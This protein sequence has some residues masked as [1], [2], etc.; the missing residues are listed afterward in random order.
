MLETL[1]SEPPQET[2]STSSADITTT[3]G[4]D[5]AEP[6]LTSVT[7]NHPDVSGPTDNDY[8]FGSGSSEYAYKSSTLSSSNVGDFN[9]ERDYSSRLTSASSGFTSNVRENILTHPVVLK[10]R[11]EPG[12]VS[13]VSSESRQVMRKGFDL[14]IGSPALRM[15][16]DTRIKELE[17]ELEMERLSK[18]KVEKQRIDL[19]REVSVL[20]EKVDE[21]TEATHTQTELVRRREADF[22]KLQKDL[23]D[24][25][26]QNESTLTAFR[27]KHQES[28]NQ[29]A[30]QI[31]QMQRVKQR[32]EKEKSLLKVEADELHSQ[33][34]QLT[35]SKASS[36]KLNKQLESQLNEFSNKLNEMQRELLDS[37][38]LRGRV[39]TD[40]TEL[41]RKLEES[42]SQLS[43]ANRARL[44]ASKQLEEAKLSLEDETIVRNK[45]LSDNR[46][47]QGQLEQVRSTLEEEQERVAELQRQVS[48]VTG[49]AS[50]WKQKFESG[51]GSIK[52]EEVEELKKKFVARLQ[53][54]ETQLEA[55]VSKAMGLEKAK[56]R[57]Q[58]EIE[59]LLGELEKSQSV[60]AQNE[61]RQ[62]Q[63][64]KLVE[65]WKRKVADLQVEL[66]SAQKES[67]SH[68][69]EVYKIKS[70][71]DESRETIETLRRDNKNL[72]QEIHD[73][74]DALGQSN[75][76]LQEVEKVSRRHEI[77][78]DE[79]Q[80]T[81]EEAEQ[82]LEQ[83]EAKM[84]RALM[85]VQAIKQDMERRL[86]EKEEEFENTRK[87]HQRAIESLQ[88]SL[89]AEARG[90]MDALRMKK[91]MEQDI[92]ELEM[93]LD[94]QNKS[95]GEVEKTFKKYQLQIRELQQL[96]DD[97]QRTKR[98]SKEEITAAE[99][100]AALLAGELEEMKSQIE[101]LE[102]SKKTVEGDLYE[103]A[104]RV[105]ELTAAN[106]S[107]SAA[108]KKLEADL[109]AAHGEF[110]DHINELKTMDDQAKKAMT[111][112]ARLAEEL[113]QEQDHASQIDKVRRGLE[114]QIKE[115]QMRL[116]ESE[117]SALHGGRKTIQTLEQ[118]VREVQGELEAEQHRHTETQKVT[119]KHE[120]RAQELTLQVEEDRKAQDRMHDMIDKMQSKM[121]S[122]KKQV[123]EAEEI[124]AINLT[125]YRKIQHDLE[126][127]ESRADMAENLVG[128]MRAKSR[129]SQSVCENY[130]QPASGITIKTITTRSNLS[131]DRKLSSD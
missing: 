92:N 114:A 35:K 127:S 82:A 58:L 115:L 122:Y 36:E 64:D 131:C 69:T 109:Q 124:A 40:N 57:A 42:E 105:T 5:V 38:S 77:Q 51:E 98:T 47:L 13:H 18:C 56:N 12:F 59:S 119:R 39:Q 100:R 103:A 128:H 130:S 33:I 73:L 21:A 14:G 6:V 86:N 45:V 7:V 87:N 49:E 74:T 31:E 32:Q 71:V 99:R 11:T 20:S 101:T 48:K 19:Q 23:E 89:E 123:E 97:E 85:E 60:N 102:R 81:L 65:E 84:S 1:M 125:K 43:Q 17:E 91:K 16:Y 94:G 113:R 50:M 120:R 70:Q 53:E 30:E 75:Q 63:F 67:R 4:G 10:N 37:T 52:P 2:T 104:D 95:K 44:I 8:Q 121:K 78:K 15:M 76:K 54:T 88:A 61:K 93:A 90:K 24:C 25:Q 29:L 34:E 117:A 107:L 27:K 80:V 22:Q 62:R 55:V 66:D 26:A 116:D 118:R 106:A 112:A 72:S 83:E 9:V 129:T 3:S 46:G 41:Q 108:K 126:E 68:A 96:L 79:L 111:D 110:D 28:V